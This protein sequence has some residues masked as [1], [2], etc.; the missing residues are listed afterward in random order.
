MEQALFSWKDRDADDNWQQF[1]DCVLKQD[2]FG[3]KTGHHIPMIDIDKENGIIS[4][5]ENGGG[6]L[7]SKPAS[8][9]KL[10]YTVGEQIK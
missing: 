3:Y 4:L 8:K 7:G 5:F 9:W 10:S 1:A 2:L 6:E